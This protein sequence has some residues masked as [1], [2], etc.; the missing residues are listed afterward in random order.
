M[1]PLHCNPLSSRDDDELCLNSRNCYLEPP[2][3]LSPP[4]ISPH[5]IWSLSHFASPC[6]SSLEP[7][8]PPPSA[9]RPA[10]PFSDVPPL[11]PSLSRVSFFLDFH[12]FIAPVRSR[13]MQRIGSCSDGS[14]DVPSNAVSSS[15]HS[16]SR[17]NSMSVTS[18]AA[19][20]AA[21]AASFRTAE[22]SKQW[23]CVASIVAT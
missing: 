18:E 10:P 5:L 19:L 20:A 4:S 14:D 11:L 13:H 21:A 2:S 16:S 15:K 17:S 8:A 6:P 3:T 7:S 1:R 9:L 12:A 23:N 22:H